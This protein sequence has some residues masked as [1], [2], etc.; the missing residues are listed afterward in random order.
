MSDPISPGSS[1]GAVFDRYGK[2]VGITVA[3]VG[4][5]QNLNFAVPINWAKP[6][7]RGGTLRPLADVTAEN[8]VTNDVLDGSVTVDA[9]KA[10][11]WNFVVNANAMSNPEILGDITSTGGMG[12]KITLALYLQDQPNPL[13]LCRETACTI[14]QK[15]IAPGNYVLALDNRESPMFTRTV[16]GKLFMRYVK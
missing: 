9:Q 3:T 8:T 2:V 4:A 11:S 14:H 7:L 13:F 1:G 15:L 10:K 5:G 6:Y 16:N 12:G